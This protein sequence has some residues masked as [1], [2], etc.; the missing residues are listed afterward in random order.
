MMRPL[1]CTA[2]AF[3]KPWWQHW[4]FPSTYWRAA[5]CWYQRATRGWA[6]CDVWGLDSYICDVMVPALEH[7]K[8]TKQGTPVPAD[9][10][11]DENGQVTEEE[12]ARW[13]KVWDQKL[14]AMIAGFRAAGEVSDGPPERFF[15]EDA[16]QPLG[17][18]MDYEACKVW[19]Q[20][21]ETVRQKGFAAF[22]ENFYSLWD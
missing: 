8:K 16:T 17:L 7:L 2:R 11:L 5:K 13:E 15:T 14:D 4:F 18:R 22:T 19:E 10:V 9:G 6:D 20:E 21:Q 12:S 1:E 3:S